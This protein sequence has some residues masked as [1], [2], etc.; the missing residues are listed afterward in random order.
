[1]KANHLLQLSTLALFIVMGACSGEKKAETTPEE[2]IKV[3]V[4]TAQV[5]NIQQQET[6]TAN[7]E[8]EIVNQIAPAIPARIRKIYVDVG[9]YVS[10]GQKLVDMDNTSLDQQQVQLNNLEKDYQR[11]QELFKSGGVSQQQ[12]DQM[13]TQVDVMRTAISNLKENSALLSP[14]SGTITARN[15]DNGDVFG[16]KP[17]LTVEQLNPAKALVYISET[18]FPKVKVGMPVDIRLDIYEG[19]SFQG[20]VKLIYPTIDPNTHTFGCEISIPNNQMK[21]RPGMFARVAFNFGEMPHVTVP[22]ASVIKQTGSNDRFVYTVVD[23]KAVY[24]TVRV[25]QRLNDKWEI[26]SGINPGDVV[27]TTGQ[28]K[29]VDGVAVEIIK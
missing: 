1:M 10:K 24:N 11:Y 5:E 16:Q 26:L 27:V 28:T 17:I 12:L 20:K 23:G 2:K 14:I 4:Q 8:A 25:G 13:K 6:F 21:V 19:E 22:D 9:N 29:L 7:I 15:Y 18:F 3:T